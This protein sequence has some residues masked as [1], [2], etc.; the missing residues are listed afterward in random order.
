MKK[1]YSSPV[2]KAYQVNTQ[3]TIL[4]GSD[5]DPIKGLS[6]NEDNTDASKTAD[7]KESLWDEIW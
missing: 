6:I 7:S 5:P 4:A 1:T 3:N 2:T